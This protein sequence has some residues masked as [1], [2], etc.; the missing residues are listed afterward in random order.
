MISL[1]LARTTVRRVRQVVSST[2]SAGLPI[3]MPELDS[4]GFDCPKSDAWDIQVRVLGFP[5]RKF[6]GQRDLS[7]GPLWI[8]PTGESANVRWS[9]CAG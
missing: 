7:V 4:L 3:H 2:R 9:G 5:K 1:T 6:G 8:W